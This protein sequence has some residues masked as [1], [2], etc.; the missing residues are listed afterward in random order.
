[1]V[2]V[3]DGV[4]GIASAEDGAELQGLLSV[5]A[6]VARIFVDDAALAAVSIHD[7]GTV[8]MQRFGEEPKLS[9]RPQPAGATLRTSPGR[10]RSCSIPDHG[11]SS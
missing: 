10:V 8:R 11:Y 1:M 2:Y 6:N 3:V 5:P 4:A 7:D 9:A